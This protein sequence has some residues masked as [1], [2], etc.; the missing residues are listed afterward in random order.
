MPPALLVTA[1]RGAGEF[2]YKILCPKDRKMKTG[3]NLTS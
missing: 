2:H 3:K 1:D